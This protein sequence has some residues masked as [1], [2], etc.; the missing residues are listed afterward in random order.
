MVSIQY[1]KAHQKENQDAEKSF[2]LLITKH[3][4]GLYIFQHK[5]KQLDSLLC[6]PLGLKTNLDIFI[7][8]TLAY[9]PITENVKACDK[10]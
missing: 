10:Q 5:R 7:R 6:S 2:L 4:V 9:Q 1:S 3:N 8:L